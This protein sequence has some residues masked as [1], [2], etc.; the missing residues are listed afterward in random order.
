MP[1]HQDSLSSSCAQAARRRQEAL[2]EAEAI[3]YAWLK[4]NRAFEAFKGDPE[5]S[6]Q[7][8]L[9]HKML[10]QVEERMGIVYWLTFGSGFVKAFAF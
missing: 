8:K 6:D 9:A 7:G 2:R 3:G 5:P 4:A 1:K 10:W